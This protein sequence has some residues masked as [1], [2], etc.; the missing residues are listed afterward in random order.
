MYRDQDQRDFARKLRNTP[1][2]AEQKLWRFLRAQQLDGHKFRRQVAMGP[3]VVDFVCLKSRFVIELD[4][5]Q[6]G[7]GEAPEYDRRRTEWLSA[8]GYRVIRF[9]NQQVDDEVLSVIETIR[10]AL[11]EAGSAKCAAVPPP[12][13]SPP[14]GGGRT[15]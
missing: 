13:P 8:R 7:E 10:S 1:S 9:K 4:G 6:H 5:P 3:F 12:Q 14:G 2:G 11:N 15:F